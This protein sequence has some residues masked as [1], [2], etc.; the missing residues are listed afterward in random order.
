MQ[1]NKEKPYNNL[2]LLPPKVDLEST[3]IL[4]AAI[5]ANRYLAEIKG[6][7][8]LIPN[9]AIL[10]RGIVVQEA[11]LSSEIENIVTTNDNLYQAISQESPSVNP[12]TKEVLSYEK[13]LWHGVQYIKDKPIGTNLF[14]DLVNIIKDNSATI[15]STPGT[16]LRDSKN[17]VIYTPP[18]GEKEIRDLLGNLEKFIHAED[19]LDPLIKM[20]VMHYQFEAIHPFTDGNGRC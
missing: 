9:Q 6:A 11:K 10:L 18:I 5:E 7:G 15:R 14:V 13:A 2:P 3:R 1:F 19:Q 17:R 16:V 12:Q 4:K 20:A 8:D